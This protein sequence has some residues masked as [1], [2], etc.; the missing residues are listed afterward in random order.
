M[1]FLG[2]HKTEAEPLFRDGRPARKLKILIDVDVLQRLSREATPAD[3]TLHRLLQDPHV[4]FSRYSDHGPPGGAER[5]AADE[6]L[7]GDEMPGWTVVTPSDD[8]MVTHSITTVT[9]S[10]VERRALFA[11]QA[12]GPGWALAMESGTSSDADAIL[13]ATA[14]EIGADV[15]V[16]D[17]QAVLDTE[18]EDRG[19]C[20]FVAPADALPLV[21][22]FIRATGGHVLAASSS[23]VGTAHP[24]G[25]YDKAAARS[26]PSL[27][28]LVDRGQPHVSATRI[29]T[30]LR[31]ARAILEA[32]DR[33]ALLLSERV[34]VDVADAAEATFTHALVD[35][36][37][38]HDLLARIVN[39][40]LPQP[41]RVASRV[42]WQNDAWRR[43]A[44]A[45]VEQLAP[46]WGDEGFATLLNGA[47]RAARNEIHDVSPTVV[48][49][50]TR[51]GPPEVGLAFFEPVG[52]RVM[53][54]MN[55]LEPHAVSGIDR[56]FV[57]AY[58]F[59][60]LVL[61]E[62]M[63]PWMFNSVE[64]TLKAILPMLPAANTAREEGV[65]DSEN[66]G[67][68]LDAIVHVRS[69]PR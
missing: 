34:T 22:L 20:R 62:F 46:P 16:T 40:M 68:A 15:L 11:D 59:R 37:A 6:L 39:E 28:Q 44:I 47:L 26:M 67:E 66:V 35:M 3:A 38:F 9:G 53:N 32:R 60:P 49:F 18:F 1:Q 36:V 10:M 2:G 29:L 51:W 50:Q 19:N 42:K 54:A 25:F 41:E 30:A 52:V 24:R 27:T 57:D 45:H 17:R 4:E 14:H 61:M 13:I 69:I 63:L 43:R 8:A 5:L 56:P 12:R 31:R 58:V 65:L 64:A 7:E 48:P 55:K 33:L 23:F 21:A